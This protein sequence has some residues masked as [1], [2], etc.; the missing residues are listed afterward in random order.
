MLFVESVW[1][2]PAEESTGKQIWFFNDEAKTT[3]RSVT[4]FLVYRKA[5]VCVSYFH[6][7]KIE[8]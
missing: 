4:K 6:A 3:E 5:I 1:K 8:K 7:Q 2:V